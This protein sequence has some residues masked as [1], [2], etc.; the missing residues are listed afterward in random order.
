M[1]VHEADV[2]SPARS[3][4]QQ[5]LKG[6]IGGYCAAWLPG[7]AVMVDIMS[8]AEIMAVKNAS[9]SDKGPWAGAWAGEMAKKTLI[10]RA[11]KSWPT[12]PT[13]ARLDA[14]ISAGDEAENVESPAHAP[15][16]NSAPLDFSE[17]EPD[18]AAH[19]Q[20]LASAR[21]PVAPDPEPPQA[22]VTP[23]PKSA[24]VLLGATGA[25]C[26]Q[27]GSVAEWL[28]A[29]DAMM[30]ST[31]SVSWPALLRNNDPV[32]QKIQAKAVFDQRIERIKH[33]VATAAAMTANDDVPF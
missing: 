22:T 11:S 9:K 27:Y 20:A 18:P 29:F 10:K 6:L 12:T 30:E 24:A 2:F 14:A 8:V 28:D 26:G 33:H 15:A 25:V 5:P 1:P 23:P 31:A 4:S 32:F 16:P 17:P 7:G 19:Q 13:S 3:D 21:R